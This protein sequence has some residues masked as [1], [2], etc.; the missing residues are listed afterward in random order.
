MLI[1]LV[2]VA[3]GTGTQWEG[4]PGTGGQVG[5]EEKSMWFGASTAGAR[6]A[7]PW[8]ALPSEHHSVEDTRDAA[9]RDQER[10]SLRVGVDARPCD[11]L[12]GGRR[13]WHSGPPQCPQAGAY[14]D[15]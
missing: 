4:L 13:P 8:G 7:S 6:A 1:G 5:R 12:R 14:G 11:Q 3:Q 10:L 15:E 2:E 9:K